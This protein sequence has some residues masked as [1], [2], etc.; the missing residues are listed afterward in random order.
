M[1]RALFL[2]GD[3]PLLHLGLLVATIVTTFTVFW[4]FH[5]GRTDPAGALAFSLATIA[6]L[7]THEMGHYVLARRHGVDTS[8]PYFIP[9]PL[10]VGFGTLG[11]VIRIRGRIPNRNALVDIGAAGPLAGLA[12]A[13][14]VLVWGLS[15]SHVGDAPPIPQHFPGELSLYGVLEKLVRW[16]GERGAPEATSPAHPVMGLV[17][18]DSLLMRGLQWVVLGPLP[19][20][21]EVFVHPLVIAGWFGLL[22]TTLNLCPIGQLDGGHLSFAWLGHKAPAVGR[23]AALGLVVLTVFF[24]AGWLVW[25]VVTTK[26]I[27]FGH[28]EVVNPE[29]PL[30]LGRR[31]ICLI[32]LVALILCMVPVPLQEVALP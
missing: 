20:G 8:L 1:A 22:V 28:P 23:V 32:A 21:K 31:L 25:L 24:S 3:R 4:V 18:G 14:P 12:V 27:G 26:L 11:A 29:E 7:G 9:L 2:R 6:I 10:P 19:P 5:Q 15:L 13:I 30:S 17:Y 16:V